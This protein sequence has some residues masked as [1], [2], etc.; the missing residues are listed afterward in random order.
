MLLRHQS[1][2]QNWMELISIILNPLPKE[3]I[4]KVLFWEL[5]HHLQ[6]IVN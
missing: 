3:D 5:I 2:L 4:S 1:R 6:S